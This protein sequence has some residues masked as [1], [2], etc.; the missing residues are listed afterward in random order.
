M[1]AAM[2]T[3]L[4]EG[5]EWWLVPLVHKA[6]FRQSIADNQSP[7]HTR[8]IPEE[9]ANE[10]LR[11]CVLNVWSNKKSVLVVRSVEPKI[12]NKVVTMK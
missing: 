11:K 10:K 6:A 5:D 3:N 9:T 7:Q 8:N 1:A 4:F 12:N 2:L